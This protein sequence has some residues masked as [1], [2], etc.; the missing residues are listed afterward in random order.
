[1]A[2]SFLHN[3]RSSS[4]RSLFC[5]VHTLVGDGM[6]EL[7]A[8]GME[9][10]T[11]GCLSVKGIAHDGAVHAV[12]VCGMDA[13]LVGAACFGV[14]GDAGEILRFALNDTDDFIPCYR[15]LAIFEANHLEWAVI[16]VWTYGEANE[17]FGFLA[18]WSAI[19]E[20]DVAFL[21]A[22]SLELCLQLLVDIFVLSG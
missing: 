21:Y 11:V 1:M 12:G 19:Q 5:Y 20:G 8:F 9:V 10:Q 7:Q 13:E 2:G 14:V 17:A 15:W 3:K 6:A 18:L 16:I 22:T 4:K